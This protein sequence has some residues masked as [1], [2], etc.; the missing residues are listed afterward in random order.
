MPDNRSSVRLAYA[1]PPYPGQALKRYGDHPDYAGEVDHRALIERLSD[2]YDGWALSTSAAALQQVL[3]VCPSGVRIGI[4]YRS[5]SE[6][7]GNRGTWWWS[8]EPMILSAARPP[9]F[10]TRDMLSHHK[11]QGFLGS[12]L[13]GQ[14]PW[15]VCEWMFALLGAHPDDEFDDLFPGS[16][17]VTRAWERWRSELRL[18]A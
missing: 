16:G 18:A 7:P 6:H 12:T 3:A 11:E 17:A 13:I 15:P 14:K 2:E 5:N 9:L 1:D 8:W 10:P 4:W